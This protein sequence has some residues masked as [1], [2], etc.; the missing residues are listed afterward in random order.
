MIDEIIKFVKSHPEKNFSIFFIGGSNN[1]EMEKRVPLS[2][3]SCPN[4]ICHMLGYTFPVPA[5][6]V[7]SCDVGLASSN[8]VLVTSDEG[9]PTISIDMNDNKA[10]GVY[11][12]TTFRKLTRIKEP[13]VAI[14]DLLEDVLFTNNYP[15][16]KY[17]ANNLDNFEKAFES[18]LKFIERSRDNKGYYDILGMYS[19]KELVVARLKWFAHEIIRL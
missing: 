2:F 11:G 14:C 19:L 18:E 1:A 7:M 4:V 3:A 17:K 5:N 15:K 8:S 10:I 6:L 13:A 9:I 12:Y 16:G